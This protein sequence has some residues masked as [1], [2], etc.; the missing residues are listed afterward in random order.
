MTNPN[1]PN[2]NIGNAISAL[3]NQARAIG[4]TKHGST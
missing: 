3:V 4:E 2:T 1:G